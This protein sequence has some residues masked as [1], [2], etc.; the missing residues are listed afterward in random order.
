IEYD[1]KTLTLAQLEPYHTDVKAEVRRSSWNVRAAWFETHKERLDS[2]FDELVRVRTKMAET[3]GYKNYIELG[4][5]LMTRNCYDADMVAKFRAGVKKYIVPLAETVKAQQAKRLGVDHITLY[6]NAFE[7]PDGNAKPKGT[8]EEIFAA[9]KRMYHELSA[10]TAEFIDFMLENE[11]LDVLTRKGKSGGGYCCEIP[12]YDSQFIFA[13]FNGTSGDVDVFTH[14]AGH[15][16]AGYRSRDV[17]PYEL[18]NQ[19]TYEV[20]ET[21]SM[22]MEFFTHP[23]MELFFGEQT[24]KYHYSHLSDALVFIPYGTMVDEFQ[25]IVYENPELTPAQRNDVWKELES[26]YRPYLDQSEV[27]FYREGRRWQAQ[28]HIYERPFYYIDYCLAQTNALAFWTLDGKDHA[29]AWD[30]YMKFVSLAGK[31][32]FTELNEI[33]GVGSPFDELSLKETAEAAAKWLE[34]HK[35]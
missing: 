30:K 31:K 11:L 25:H 26:V 24:E 4:Y 6:D 35:I 28:S 32:T 29:D 17:R 14:E 22:S 34:E 19:L 13:N 7:F 27:A 5:Y 9:G 21:H 20:A 3:L 10:E 12:L 33:A 1:G 23:W 18:A 15:A 16:F 8:P 2:L